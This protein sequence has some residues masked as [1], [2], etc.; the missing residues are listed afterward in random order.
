MM[1]FPHEVAA[2]MLM[3]Q[4]YRACEINRGSTYHRE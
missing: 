2:A 3:E 4:I 1:T